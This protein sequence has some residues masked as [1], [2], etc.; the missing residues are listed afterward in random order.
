M[1]NNLLTQLKEAADVS[2]SEIANKISNAI[3]DKQ[4][5]D[6]LATITD[7]SD[8]YDKCRSVQTTPTL[9]FPIIVVLNKLK[10]M[11]SSRTSRYL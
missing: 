5:V 9:P 2:L 8:F 1:Y 7:Y 6:Y 4:V 11:P 10:Q 3:Y